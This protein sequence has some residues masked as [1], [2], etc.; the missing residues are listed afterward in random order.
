MKGSLLRP[1]RGHEPLATPW[2]G[3]AYKANAVAAGLKAR[4]S[5]A[6]F[7]PRYE[8][9]ARKALRDLRRACI[10]GTQLLT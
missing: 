6:L 7:A 4:S 9:M 2:A 5:P 3:H 8:S 1:P 10:A